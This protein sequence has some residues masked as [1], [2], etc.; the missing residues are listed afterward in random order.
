MSQSPNATKHNVNVSIIAKGASTHTGLFAAFA[1]KM[2]KFASLRAIMRK[3][4]QA[5]CG[6]H[7]TPH[8]SVASGKTQQA[9]M[10][11]LSPVR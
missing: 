4:T 11:R 5:F 10:N 1:L 7:K 3:F 8:H 9:V 6:N 2:G